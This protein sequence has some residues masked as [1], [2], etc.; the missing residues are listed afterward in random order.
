MGYSY[1]ANIPSH[2]DGMQ[3][4]NLL[5]STMFFVQTNQ[6]QMPT[7]VAQINN[8]VASKNTATISTSPTT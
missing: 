2:F 5:V 4:Q 6:G 1:T 3:L 7:S 8:N